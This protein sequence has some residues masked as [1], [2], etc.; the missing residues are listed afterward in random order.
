MSLRRY[1]SKLDFPVK[2]A[3]RYMGYRSAE[4]EREVLA[5][6]EK[7][8]AEMERTM[9][10][11]VCY[12]RVPVAEENGELVLSIVRT[13]G[14]GLKRNLHGC[15]EAVLFAATIGMGADRV[16]AKYAHTNPL[17]EAIAQ[18]AG[19]A[20][21]EELCDEF[22][23]ELSKE[24]APLYTRPRFSPGYGDFPLE[25]QRQF[26]A[27]LSPEREIGITL[28]DSLLM[29]PTKSVTAVV[30][31]SE[32]PCRPNARCADCERTDCVY[33]ADDKD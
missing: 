18:A 21:A 10:P 26:F 20:Y 22:C 31:L 3:L 6:V 29:S 8:R 27:L 16:L 5:E 32:T 33:R 11:A 24:C 15:K 1:Y 30:G 19:A 4:P 28:N 14:E 25:A 2:Q 9:S 12:V 17:R 13:S 23:R 7:V